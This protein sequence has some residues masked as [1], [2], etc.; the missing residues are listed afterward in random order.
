MDAYHGLQ[1]PVGQNTF[2]LFVSHVFESFQVLGNPRFR[3]IHRFNILI[4]FCTYSC[5]ISYYPSFL[6]ESHQILIAAAQPDSN[7]Q[8]AS[9]QTAALLQQKWAT[10]A[11]GSAKSFSS[12]PCLKLV[13]L[14]FAFCARLFCLTGNLH[15]DAKFDPDSARQADGRLPWATHQCVFW[16]DLD[17]RNSRMHHEFLLLKVVC[18]V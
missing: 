7:S 16:L 11:G 15:L 9:V 18:T 13:D 6:T 3:T 2:E 10:S 4:F 1:P 8:G 5:L 17:A 14:W 12:F